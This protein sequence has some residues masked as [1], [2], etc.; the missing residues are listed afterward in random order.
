MEIW[1]ISWY[2]K[3]WTVSTSIFRIFAA[4]TISIEFVDSI[5][6]EIQ[7]YVCFRWPWIAVY[8][9]LVV[10]LKFRISFNAITSS[11][12]LQGSYQG[13][14]EFSDKISDFRQWPKLS[15][16]HVDQTQA[17][18]ILQCRCWVEKAQPLHN[19]KDPSN[20]QAQHQAWHHCKI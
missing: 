3:K 7:G 9:G 13:Q 10:E 6:Y 20:N 17:P 2:R 14:H 12:E 5:W 4:D 15:S 8:L 11:F 1:L 19:P 16:G 18:S